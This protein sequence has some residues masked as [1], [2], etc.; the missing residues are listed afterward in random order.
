MSAA[1]KYKCTTEADETTCDLIVYLKN[2]WIK[3]LKD[4]KLKEGQNA[5]FEC[6]LADR[7]AMVAWYYKE[8]RILPGLDEKFEIKT[9]ANGVH[10]L[11]INSCVKAD[12]GDVKCVCDDLETKA[13]LDVKRVE[14]KPKVQ[15]EP[16][17]EEEDATIKG[18]YKGM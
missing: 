15:V 9:L 6:Q 4:V 3:K 5:L 1:G 2:K 17:Q 8:E 12:K 14:K 11:I 10:Q 13:S 16:K 7:E 18:R